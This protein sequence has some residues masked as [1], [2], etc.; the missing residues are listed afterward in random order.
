MHTRKIR[1]YFIVPVVYVGVILGLLYLQYSGTLTIRRSIDGIDF[2]A[3]ILPGGDESSDRISS[4]RI[5]FDGLVLDVSE[6]TPIRLVAEES[7]DQ[8]LIPA[9][10]EELENGVRVILSDDSSLV[11]TVTEGNPPELHVIPRGGATWSAE[12]L[13]VVPLDFDGDA[14]AELPRP[15]T[16]ES[17][18]VSYGGRDYFLSAPP[19]TQF[20]LDQGTLLVPL[21]GTSRLIRYAE[22][23]DR[24]LDVVSVAFADDQRWIGDAF[25][26]SS[27]SDFFEVA[28]RGWAVSRFNGGSGTWD[29]RDGSPLFSEEI[30]VAY[31]AE[32]W[33]RNEYTP[34]FNRMRRAADLHPD[35]IGIRSTVFLGNLREVTQQSVTNDIQRARSDLARVRSGD[36]TVFRQEDLLTFAALRG[37]DEL[38]REVVEFAGL[39]DFR[40][41]A[42][43]TA[44]GMLANAFDSEFAPAEALEATERFAAIIE[45]RIYP[46]IVQFDDYF[47]LESGQGEI[48]VRYSIRAGQLLELIGGTRGDRTVV[49]IGRNLVLSALALADDAGYLPARLVFGDSGIQGQEGS[50]GPEAIYAFFT[51][52]PSYP[53]YVP[54]YD[55]IGPGTYIYTVADFTTVDI[56]P[57]R[58]YFTLR[59]PENR[60]HY[61]IFQG[62]P[63]FD[64]MELFGLVWRDDPTFE[65]YIKGR[66]YNEETETL[67][68][69]YT[70][71]SIQG[72]IILN[73]S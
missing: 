22:L 57:E 28:Y 17:V 7:P 56:S 37:G 63:Q 10:Y 65:A 53:R 11:V 70:D 18:H 12:Q 49:A 48:D 45:E 24:R 31:L 47:F 5:A 38:F 43:P 1:R 23:G 15:G 4:A 55:E 39:V 33:Q 44:V 59:Y 30:L 60:T 69:K 29:R 25:Y 41:V 42:I 19:R 8:A 68:I 2:S 3:S 71:D 73:Y 64:T 14:V 36:P 27:L 13:L 54:L 26:E 67:M 35:E 9:R 58:F 32:A 72:E 50:F 6:E 62:V 40:N 61:V 16:P 21:A 66:H 51:E 34:A 52:N 20:D 46:A